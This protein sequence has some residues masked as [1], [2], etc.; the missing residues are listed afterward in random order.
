M[1]Y[2]IHYSEELYH[3][4]VKGMKWGVRKEYV[5]KGRR[6]TSGSTSPEKEKRKGLSRNQKIAIGIAAVAVTGVVLY[7]TGSFDRIAE[8]GKKAAE[9]KGA[10]NG[11]DITESVSSA[12]KKATASEI[13]DRISPIDGD[14]NFNSFAGALSNKFNIRL[15][16]NASEMYENNITNL[17]GKALKNPDKHIYDTIPADAYRDKERLSNVILTKVAKGNDG[18]FGQIGS[19]LVT[20]PGAPTKG[21]AFNWIVENGE[22]RFYDTHAKVRDKSTGQIVRRALE[23]ASKY[24]TQGRISGQHG[25]ITR[26]DN[27]E[28]EDFNLDYMGKLCSEFSKR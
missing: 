13:R 3:H 17:L 24:I 26:L 27:I 21:H 9:S 28:F 4:G 12:T 6:K 1:N 23:D 5:P 20:P 11:I 2:R 7:K 10:V 16:P 15:N 8:I 14:C 25:K 22:V 19:D 18:A